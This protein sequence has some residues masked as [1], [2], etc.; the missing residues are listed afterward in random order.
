MNDSWTQSEREYYLERPACAAASL[1]RCDVL[2]EMIRCGQSMTDDDNG[3]PLCD[4]TRNSHIDA[5][6]LLLKNG[7]DVDGRDRD[8]VAPLHIAIVNGDA[9]AAEM[10]IDYGAD[11]DEFYLLKEAVCSDAN[12][13]KKSTAMTRLLLN[14]GTNVNGDFGY[15]LNTAA[16]FGHVDLVTLLLE[17]GASVNRT[18][19]HWQAKSALEQ[20]AQSSHGEAVVG[21]LLTHGAHTWSGMHNY[22]RIAACARQLERKRL[23]SLVVHLLPLNLPT[24]VVIAIFNSLRPLFAKQTS[25][26]LHI[27]WRIVTDIKRTQQ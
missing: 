3:Q 22:Q 27:V 24:L 26:P 18:P 4:A 16:R 7:A 13:L 5:M 11:V 10:L 8:N 21:I 14:N 9:T 6:R 12:C 15:A 23:I 17:R 25:L 2:A 19:G 1:G 20:A